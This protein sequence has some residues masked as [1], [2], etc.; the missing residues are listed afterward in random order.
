MTDA[1]V[2]GSHIRT[3]LLTFFYRQ[4]PEVVDKGY[5]YIAQPP[6]LKIG[7]GKNEI[8][9]KNER[10]LNDYV[11]K[12]IADSE[13]QDPSNASITLLYNISMGKWDKRILEYLGL[14][15]E[16]LSK[17]KKSGEVAGNIKKEIRRKLR[18]KN[19]VKVI[20]GGHDQYCAAVGAGITDSG[21]ILLST[22]TAWVIFKMLE[23][24]LLDTDNFFSVGRNIIDKAKKAGIIKSLN[25]GISNKKE[26]KKTLTHFSQSKIKR[27]EK[28][29]SYKLIALKSSSSPLV[30]NE[31]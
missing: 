2:D 23:Q 17:V 26:M 4:M 21:Q 1:D 6:L 15:V 5:L 14:S 13:I 22:G 28:N 30:I 11:L 18:I 16:Q 12:R 24:H 7:K 19:E 31:E 27:A 3:L 25:L 10:E 9:F 29:K 8:Y 20:N